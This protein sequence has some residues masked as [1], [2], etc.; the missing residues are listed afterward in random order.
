MNKCLFIIWTNFLD[1]WDDITLFD[2]SIFEFIISLSWVKVN[3][4][5]SENKINLYIINRFFLNF[6]II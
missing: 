5:Q 4:N 6:K 2:I 1:T 3:I